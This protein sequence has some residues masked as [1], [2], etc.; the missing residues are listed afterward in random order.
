[1]EEMNSKHEVHA[2]ELYMRS[3]FETD[4]LMMS[5]YLLL[6]N[7]LNPKMGVLE[8]SEQEVLR[9]LERKLRQI[10][11]LLQ[12]LDDAPWKHCVEDV[13]RICG[14]HMVLGTEKDSDKFRLNHRIGRHLAFM[15]ELA[16]GRPQIKQLLSIFHCHKDNVRYL[17][18]KC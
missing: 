18:E 4:D 12:R 5:Y 11:D 15:A 1:M 9:V 13:N 14:T 17:L 7:I 16:A 10:I 6:N 2:D 8:C 3:A